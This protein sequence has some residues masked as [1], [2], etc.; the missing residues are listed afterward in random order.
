[1]RPW[2]WPSVRPS[3]RLSRVFSN[4]EKRS[5]KVNEIVNN[6]TMRTDEIVASDVPLR[7]LFLS[8]F[9]F[10]SSFI[11]NARYPWSRNEVKKNPGFYNLRNMSFFPCNSRIIPPFWEVFPLILTRTSLQLPIVSITHSAHPSGFVSVLESS[12]CKLFTVFSLHLPWYI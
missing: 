2:P 8:L 12:N 1:M 10:F 6:Y 5:Y 7:F 3:V 9:L 4:D 11:C